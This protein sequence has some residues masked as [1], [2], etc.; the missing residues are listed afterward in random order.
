MGGRGSSSGKAGSRTGGS[1]SNTQNNAVS[2]SVNYSDLSKAEKLNYDIVSQDLQTYEFRYDSKNLADMRRAANAF[3]RDYDSDD[4][5]DSGLYGKGGAMALREY[6]DRLESDYNKE[7]KSIETAA[8]KYESS[9]TQTRT[10]K[11]DEAK[12]KADVEER[13]RNFFSQFRNRKK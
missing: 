4:L 2:K 8:K 5:Q 7:L 6:R 13:R 12:A 9:K 1:A 10:A 3:N 11:Y